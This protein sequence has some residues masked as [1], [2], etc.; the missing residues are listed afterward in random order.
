MKVHMLKPNMS[1]SAAKLTVTMLTFG[2]APLSLQEHP[3]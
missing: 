2:L 3:A 1:L